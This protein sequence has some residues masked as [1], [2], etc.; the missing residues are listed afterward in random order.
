M[1][2]GLAGPEVE[3][4]AAAETNVGSAV[5]EVAGWHSAPDRLCDR[6]GEFVWIARGGPGH[7]LVIGVSG[8]FLRSH[9]KS[10][11]LGLRRCAGRQ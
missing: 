1:T 3:P 8:A 9:D 5:D 6:P 2:R 10:L 7:L 11:D 4:A